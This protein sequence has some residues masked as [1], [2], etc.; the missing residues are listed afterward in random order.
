MSTITCPSCNAIALPG[1]AFCDH[2][3][4][5]LRT[6]EAGPEPTPP[7]VMPPAPP[8]ET[9]QGNKI[10]CPVCEFSN[11]SGA[12]FCEYCGAELVDGAKTPSSEPTLSQ[13]KPEA[14]SGGRL[15]IQATNVSFPISADKQVITIGREDP[16]GGVF[17]DIDL[18]P[19]G[20][21]DSGVGRRHAQVLVKGDQIYLEDLAS[22]N[23]TMVNRHRVEPHQPC[24]LHP[25]DEVRLG[26]LV[27]IYQAG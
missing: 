26:K 23:G 3:G 1:A 12:L 7:P 22:V 25:G 15:V 13:I 24:L 9:L 20:G 16:V 19:H 14:S 18:E 17:P 10:I 8:P 4:Y 2:C 11:I 27:M 6:V 5:D 21:H